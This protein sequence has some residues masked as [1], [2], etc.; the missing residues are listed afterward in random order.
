MKLTSPFREFIASYIE[1]SELS[2]FRVGERVVRES[3]TLELKPAQSPFVTYPIVETGKLMILDVI[4]NGK[5]NKI[6]GFLRKI[7]DKTITLEIGP[8]SRHYTFTEGTQVILGPWL[9]NTVEDIRARYI[10]TKVI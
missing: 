4:V 6:V 8:S 9:P 5:I 7:E 2:T 3:L 10:V 1:R